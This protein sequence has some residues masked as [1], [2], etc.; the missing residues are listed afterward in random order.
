MIQT[1]E[2]VI[3]EQGKV[4]LLEDVHL[5]QP[6]RA[7]VTILEDQPPAIEEIQTLGQNQALLDAINA[8]YSDEAELEEKELLRLMKIKQARILDKW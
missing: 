1:V 3:D 4:R 7:L 6:R 2:A 8:A 5:S